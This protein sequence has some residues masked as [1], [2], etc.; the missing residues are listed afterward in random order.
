[1]FVLTKSTLALMISFIISVIMGYF[2]IPLLKKLNIPIVTYWNAVDLIEDDN[3]LYCGRAGNMGDRAGNWAIQNA[4]LILV[5]KD[6]NIIETGNHEE[7][8]K[9]NGFYADLYNSQFEL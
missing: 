5:M 6:G 8:M 3:Y 2:M 1:M 4:D 7:L 9:K